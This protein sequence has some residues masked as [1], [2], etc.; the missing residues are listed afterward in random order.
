MTKLEEIARA[1]CV[2]EGYAV[3]A[4]KAG[5]YG[6]HANTWQDFID[7]AR[8][9]VEVMMTP[10][11]GMIAACDPIYHASGDEVWKADSE[12]TWSAMCRAILDETPT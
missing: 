9:A 7:D 8:T 12:D 11:A 3:E 1:I 4:L 10:S 2:R 6:E 5:Q